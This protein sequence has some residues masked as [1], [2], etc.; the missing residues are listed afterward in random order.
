MTLFIFLKIG[1]ESSPEGRWL[2]ILLSDDNELS[3]NELAQNELSEK[4]ASAMNSIKE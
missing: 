1:L 4:E 2:A 3:Q